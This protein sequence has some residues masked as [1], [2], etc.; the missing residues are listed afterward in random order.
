MLA[1]RC[2]YVGGGGRRFNFV[3]SVFGVLVWAAVGCAATPSSATTAGSAV[4][5]LA[6]RQP[7]TIDPNSPVIHDT[8]TNALVP[9]DHRLFAATDQWE[10]PGPDAY[11]QVLVKNQ[12]NGP[13]QVFEQTQG[14]RVQALDSFRAPDGQGLAP[15]RSLL[16]TQAVLDGSS[17]VQWALDGA[18]SFAPSD[19]Y[20]LSSPDDDVR[21]FGAHEAGGQWAVYAGAN[22]TGI[23]RGVWSPSAHTLVFSATPELRVAAGAPGVPAQKFTGFA[24]CAG[25]LYATVNNKLYRR[26]DGS[27]GAGVARWV[28]VYQESLVAA[29][30]SGLRGLTCIRQNGSPTLLLSTEGTGDVYRVDHLPRGRIVAPASATPGHGVRGLRPI[31]EFRPASAIRPMLARQG[32]SVPAKGTGSIGY[33]IAAYNNDAFQT[34]KI[35]GRQRQVF[36]FEWGYLG[37]CLPT[38]TCGPVAF[39]A[40]HFD[41]AACFAIRTATGSAVRYT[42]RCLSGPDFRL[43][44][45]V[46]NPISAG[47]AFV[48]I[49]S[50]VPSPFGDHRLYY[51]G[52]DCNFHPANGTAWIASSTLD[53]IQAGIRKQRLRDPFRR[54]QRRLAR[55]VSKTTT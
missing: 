26:N 46:S 27:L 45:Q 55:S 36:G 5:V 4:A 44:G 20:A 47:Q 54:L 35:D 16:V 33:V 28:L 1:R 41:A 34:V 29:H 51:S 12:S 37:S 38:R 40:A 22:P 17:E 53:A 13:W 14:L 42:T 31:L 43:S 24:D 48:S 2:P 50:I 39:G 6:Q 11:G 21:A 10:Y 23:L 8:E 49:R 52:Y 3:L 7:L 25:A 19:S 32:M 18:S 9:Q 15:G 30:N